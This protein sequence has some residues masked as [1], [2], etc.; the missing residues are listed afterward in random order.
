MMLYKFSQPHQ[1]KKGQE[2]EKKH[3]YK[4]KI[5]KNQTDTL[6][7]PSSRS[8]FKSNL[9]TVCGRKFWYSEVEVSPGL[10]M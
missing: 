3:I 1:A 6:S 4:V 8:H 9:R 10:S 7:I 2:V 5:I